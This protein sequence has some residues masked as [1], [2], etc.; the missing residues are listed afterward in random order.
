MVPKY[1]MSGAKPQTTLPASRAEP[2][3]GS[4]HLSTES[5]RREAE[6]TTNT[7]TCSAGAG[8]T[9]LIESA[10]VD[11]VNPP[12]SLSYL[13]T[14]RH[15]PGGRRASRCTF[16][17][18]QTPLAQSVRVPEATR[19]QRFQ[20]PRRTQPTTVYRD[21]DEP[22]DRMAPVTVGATRA[23]P[24]E[25]RA[26]VSADSDSPAILRII[27]VAEL[28]LVHICAHRLLVHSHTFPAMSSTP[29]G[30]LPSG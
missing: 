9:G 29:N 24:S 7:C 26:A 10:A 17:T 12:D 30:L 20:R 6:M 18:A 8:S 13:P 22:I 23:A 2:S 5:A 25:T 27:R 28:G 3:D 11:S 1:S 4:T 21:A 15:D 19:D 16:R 14:H